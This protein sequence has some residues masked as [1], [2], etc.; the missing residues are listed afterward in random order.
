MSMVDSSSDRQTTLYSLV[1][2]LAGAE[3]D[4]R[5][6]LD[7]FV[8][9]YGEPLKTYLVTSMRLDDDV[10]HDILQDFFVKKLLDPGNQLA[11]RF[12][13]MRAH[14]KRPS[15][16]NVAFAD[17]LVLSTNFGNDDVG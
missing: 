2:G 1:A 11:S 16:G 12:L 7:R 6:Y 10:S 3:E 15:D 13:E 9:L 17:F 8:A 4:R 5:S 14:D